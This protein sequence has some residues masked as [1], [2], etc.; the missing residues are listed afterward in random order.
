MYDI[1]SPL[2][3]LLAKEGE[4]SKI[5]FDMESHLEDRKSDGGDWAESHELITDYFKHKLGFKD[6]EK[7]S[8]LTSSG[9]MIPF[10]LEPEP[11]LEPQ[12]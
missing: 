2:R 6:T 12:P 7:A 11:E 4:D 8:L 10:F 1:I 5:F 9:V 3:V